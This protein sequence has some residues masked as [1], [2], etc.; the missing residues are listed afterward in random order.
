[1][2]IIVQILLAIEFS[3][4]LLIIS[5]LGLIRYTKKLLYR[6]LQKIDPDT[7]FEDWG[8]QTKYFSVEISRTG[9]IRGFRI[10]CYNL[11]FFW[12]IKADK[13][14]L[15]RKKEIAELVNEMYNVLKT[16]LTELLCDLYL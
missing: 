2:N 4:T 11:S 9:F 12:Y 3:I 15:P 8:I 6:E 5:D 1:M 16:T 14:I 7:S 13:I 10:T